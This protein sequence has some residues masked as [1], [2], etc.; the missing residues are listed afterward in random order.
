[1]FWYKIVI[2]WDWNDNLLLMISLWSHSAVTFKTPAFWLFEFTHCCSSFVVLFI[3]APDYG[4]Q[5]SLDVIF[6]NTLSFRCHIHG[7]FCDTKMT[8]N[9]KIWHFRKINTPPPNHLHHIIFFR[10]SSSA[11]FR[12][13][14]T[15]FRLAYMPFCNF[16]LF[17][18]IYH[19]IKFF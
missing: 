13:L 12:N 1:M 9:D 11:P 7:C 16:F 10:H 4:R 18:T 3:R 14:V 17:V 6:G 15:E 5:F 8:G 2:K 19:L